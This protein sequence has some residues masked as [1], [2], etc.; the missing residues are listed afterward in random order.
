MREKRR[1]IQSLSIAEG[2]EIDDLKESIAV[3]HDQEDKLRDDA[4]AI[5]K[6]TN[7]DLETTDTDYVF[8]T[9]VMENLP[10]GIIGLL[11]A[12]IFFCGYVFNSF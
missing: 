11:L 5:I 1:Q 2:E 3:I 4:K 8:I 10:K 6:A 7:Q 9:F 12:V